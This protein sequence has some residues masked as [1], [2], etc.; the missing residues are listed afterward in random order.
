MEK[1]PYK[2]YLS[3]E[4][5]PKNWYN[6]KAVMKELPD[7]FLHPGTLQPMTADEL[8]PIFCDELV[9]QEMNTK[10]EYIPIPEGVTD[11]Y[12]MYRPSPL[13][14]AYNLEK[15][16]GTPAKIYFKFEGNNTSGSHKLNSAAAQVYYAKQ[17]GIESLT[18]ETG[19]GQWGSALSMACAY[20]GVPL[21]VFM[22]KISSEQKPYRKVLMETYG[23]K[24]HASPSTETAVGRRIL[25]E[26]PGT[27]GSLGCAISE[28]L[29][30]AMSR[31][32]C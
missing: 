26:N 1:I 23:A 10:D 19:A 16:L 31:K 3:E 22:V 11:Y 21:D 9:E 32:N 14:R 29:E 5:M 8:K 7:P 28:A 27:G 24:V 4:E 6:I 18:T 13:V 2:I 20:Y 12:R 17:Q 30:T 25:E 15:Q